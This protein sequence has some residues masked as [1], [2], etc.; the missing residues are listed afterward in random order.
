MEPQ[1]TLYRDFISAHIKMM[2][3]IIKHPLSKYRLPAG[4]LN[5]FFP[6]VSGDFARS[7][8]T[9]AKKITIADKAKS[10]AYDLKSAL[11]WLNNEK[12]KR[13]YKINPMFREHIIKARKVEDKFD[14]A[15]NLIQEIWL[16]TIYQ[17]R[18][19]D[20]IKDTPTFY[21]FYHR[22]NLHHYT[23]IPPVVTLPEG[24]ISN[25]YR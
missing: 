14:D 16:P 22:Q 19:P 3:E 2:N 1:E 15:V 7:D 20:I 23:K 13:I 9:Y 25:K 17:F 4:T 12:A 24:Y 8:L 11:P 6:N 5:R 10:I 18:K 21:D